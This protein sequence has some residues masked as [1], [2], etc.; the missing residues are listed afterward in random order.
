MPQEK[1]VNRKIIYLYSVGVALMVLLLF[2]IKPYV[3]SVVNVGSPVCA[4]IVPRY[5]TQSV[6]TLRSVSL[7]YGWLYVA[8]YNNVF[9]VARLVRKIDDTIAPNCIAIGV[10]PDDKE[11]LH[12]TEMD[13]DVSH[14]LVFVLPEERQK[15]LKYLYKRG[16]NSEDISR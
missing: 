11:K 12:I 6:S 5:D 1:V 16:K 9:D 2:L 4:A 14:V 8:V 10:F 13:N 7:K 3:L 15:M